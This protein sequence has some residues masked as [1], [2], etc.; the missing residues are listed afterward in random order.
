VDVTREERARAADAPAAAAR[1][2]P[3]LLPAWGE[4]EIP[5]P[6]PFTFKNAVRLIGVG[7]ILLGTAIGSGEW[8]LGPAVTAKYGAALLWIASMS[9]IMQTIWNQEMVRYTVATGEPIFTGIMR[10]WPGPKF[11]GP[12]YAL[13]LV[14]QV[15]WPGWAIT[16]ATAITAAFKGSIPTADDSGTVLAWGYAT[17]A[18]AL[19]IFALGKKVERTLELAEGLMVAWILIFLI[20]V[21]VFFCSAAAWATVW[22]GFIG[23]GGTP[24]P[25]RSDW[26]LLAGFAVYAG[27]GGITNGTTTNWIRD[28]GWGMARMSGYIPSAIGGRKVPLS[29]VGKTFPLTPE[30]LERFRGWMK[31]VKFEQT[32]VFGVGCFLGMSL[33]A[34]MTVQFVPPGTELGAGWGAAVHQANG[35]AR[36]FGSTAWFLTLLNG[37]WILFSTQLGVTDTFT[38]T[39]TDIAWSASPRIRKLVGEDVRR[40]Y[41]ALL[42]V[43]ALF[44]MW[45]INQA[46]PITLII[47]GAFIAGFNTVV[48]GIHT[49]V[50]QRKFLPPQLRMSAW[51]TAVL[52]AMVLTFTFFTILGIQSRWSDILGLLGL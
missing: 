48:L 8:L 38:R 12:V 28:K 11:W 41:Y 5:A 42:I 36:V 14:F 40:I 7:T 26:L 6:P 52:V 23:L 30:G 10:T 24:I 27:S 35:I 47:I 3:G 9:I 22:G 31:F 50:V 33:P 32:V 21:A 49:I 51:R 46:Q 19:I 37:F 4:A 25:E 18:A 45:A 15:G 17:F 16:G 44:G 43:F 29:Q 2:D 1:P 39:V 20:I 13:L 34:I